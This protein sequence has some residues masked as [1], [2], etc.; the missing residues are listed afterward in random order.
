MHLQ[1]LKILLKQE[2]PQP[3]SCQQTPLTQGIFHPVV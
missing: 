2:Y 3:D 1:F